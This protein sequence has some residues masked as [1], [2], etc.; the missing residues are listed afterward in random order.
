MYQSD[1][2]EKIVLPKIILGISNRVCKMTQ[3]KSL[4]LISALFSKHFSLSLSPLS[5]KTT[6]YSALILRPPMN[7]FVI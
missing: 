5:L 2:S 1:K 7:C 6:S 3:A 4:I